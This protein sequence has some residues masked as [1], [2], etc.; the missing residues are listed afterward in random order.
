MSF[1]G[2]LVVFGLD[3]NHTH[4]LIDSSQCDGMRTMR[5]WKVMTGKKELKEWWLNGYGRVLPLSFL[6]VVHEENS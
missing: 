2:G 6:D 4:V 3:L 1:Q 5:L